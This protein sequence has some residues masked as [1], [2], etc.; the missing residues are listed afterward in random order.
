[1][2]TSKS[3]LLPRSSWSL[4]LQRIHLI[5]GSVITIVIILATTIFVQ[6]YW[7]YQAV[8]ISAILRFAK[9]PHELFLPSS[10]LGGFLNAIAPVFLLEK[11]EISDALILITIIAILLAILIIAVVPHLSPP[12]RILA[13]FFLA[14]VLVN[15]AYGI[16]HPEQ[17][18]PL[19]VDWL[20]SG[21]VIIPLI[22]LVFNVTLF[23][24]PGSLSTKL[25]GLVGCLAFSFV[26]STLRLSLALASL[27]Y[28]GTFSFMFLEYL[29]GAFVD[30]VYMLLFYSL[31]MHRLAASSA[32]ETLSTCRS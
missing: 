23:P 15:L 25:L 29:P 24:L 31:V 32:M 20:T 12:L 19:K 17:P 14:L 22:A 16:L 6:V 11:A 4:P 28:L 7:I 18:S 9:V 21:I 26:W 1:M 27:F 5:L 8:L 10:L 2:R 13:I 3:T 30:F